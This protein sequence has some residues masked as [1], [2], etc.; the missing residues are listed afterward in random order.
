M[1][2]GWAPR[3]WWR[4]LRLLTWAQRRVLVVAVLL[5]PATRAALRR[6]GFTATAARL[7]RWSSGT[8]RSH[9]KDQAD[10]LVEAVALVAGRTLRGP[11]CLTRSMV[12]WFLLRRRGFDA[13]LRLGVPVATEGPFEAHAWVE[14]DGAVVWEPADVQ[15]RFDPF[16]LQLPRL[17]PSGDN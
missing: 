13:V 10:Q 8:A 12:A 16:D 2:T 3:R 1:T 15:E 5:V 4:R 7:A 9:N 17:T 6:P 14:L 11:K